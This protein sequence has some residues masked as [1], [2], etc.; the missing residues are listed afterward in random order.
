MPHKMLEALKE[1]VVTQVRS[2][3]PV[4]SECTASGSPE[5]L[6]KYLGK[7]DLTA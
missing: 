7:Y 3:H 1:H 4:H 6:A 2:F 5:K